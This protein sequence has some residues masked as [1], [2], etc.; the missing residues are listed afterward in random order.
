MGQGQFLIRVLLM[1]YSID[2]LIYDTSMF[3][4]YD[5]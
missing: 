2:K 4:E 3:Y 5:Q 1:F